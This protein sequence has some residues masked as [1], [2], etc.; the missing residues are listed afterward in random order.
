M[1]A[2]FEAATMQTT[3]AVRP[4]RRLVFPRQKLTHP[5]TL[6][7]TAAAVDRAISLW[8]T[9]REE[10]YKVLALAGL[11]F[12]FDVLVVGG[13]V[14]RAAGTLAPG[15]I[16]TLHE[17]NVVMGNNLPQGMAKGQF[18]ELM[19][20]GGGH[21]TARAQIGRLSAQELRAAGVTAEMAKNWARAYEAIARI[22]P[23]NP[24]AA[25]RA[26]L[27]RWV[28]QHLRGQ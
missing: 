18:G 1:I 17:A 23:A 9:N 25:W 24:S 27:M 5:H 12:A 2:E 4:A 6:T 11:R 10:A 16:G 13:L 26:D 15:R 28:A 19:Q 22:T 21:A 20:W 14:Y 3:V 8:S 7:A